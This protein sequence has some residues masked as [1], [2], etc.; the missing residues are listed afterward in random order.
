MTCTTGHSPATTEA[1]TRCAAI[2]SAAGWPSDTRVLDFETFAAPGYDLRKMSIPEYVADPRFEMLGATVD[3]AWYPGDDWVPLVRD[4]PGTLIVHNAYFELAV[5]RLRYGI[6]PAHVIDT[7]ALHRHW[8]ARARHGMRE[9]AAE[10]GLPAKGDTKKFLGWT[11]R[12]GRHYLQRRKPVACPVITPAMDAELAEYANHDGVLTRAFFEALL[13]RLTNPTFELAVLRHSLLMYQRPLLTVPR[14]RADALEAEMLAQVGVLLDK[15]GADEKT[16]RAEAPFKRMIEAALVEAGDELFRYLK[17]TKATAPG[18]GQKRILAI[19]KTDDQRARL[20][21]HESERVRDLMAARH[22]TKAWPTWAKRVRELSAQCHAAGGDLMAQLNYHGAHT[23]RWSGGGGINLQNL[24]ARDAHDL[25]L[26]IRGLIE[27]PAGHTLVVADASQIEARVLAWEAGQDD[28]VRRFAAGEEIYCGFAEKVLGF[29]VWKPRDTDPAPVRKKMKWARNSVGKVGV[30]GCGYG[31]GAPKAVDYSKGAI[32]LPMAERLV[33]T[34]R[35]EN[36][37]IVRYWADLEAAFRAAT[38][39]ET[40]S[41][42]GHCRVLRDGD[43]TVIELPSG[44][45]LRYHGARLKRGRRELEVWNPLMKVYDKVYGGLLTENVIQAISRD[46]FAHGI[47]MM[48]DAGV[49]VSLIV[50]DEIVSP[51][52]EAQAEDALATAIRC[53]STAPDWAPGCP[54]GAEGMVSKRYAK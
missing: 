39:C 2:L 25:I 47:L 45:W 6:T 18:G 21:N 34:Y 27:A 14:Q 1:A 13:P 19:A 52:P 36:A 24:P 46:I 11:R 17:P 53:L 50:H 22:G 7:I 54:L 31:M 35:E 3:G 10:L 51:V 33:A 32:D 30:L 12:P 29:P 4:Y 38:V 15:V 16:I 49:P 48:E 42:V 26:S 9:V 28:L 23:G 44:R 20:D 41:Q 37:A 5:L 8:R 43:C 40:E